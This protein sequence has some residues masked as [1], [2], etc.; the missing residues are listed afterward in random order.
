MLFGRRVRSMAEDNRSVADVL[1]VVDGDRGCGAVAKHVRRN[2]M[3]EGC[4]CVFDDPARQR[5]LLEVC[6][7]VGNPERVELRTDRRRLLG[8]NLVRGS[9]DLLSAQ[10]NQPMAAEITLEFR[11]ERGREDRLIWDAGLGLLGGELD[12]P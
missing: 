12:L 1:R 10:E 4:P 11:R 5:M 8:S 9:P 3:A 6:S 2:A 7:D